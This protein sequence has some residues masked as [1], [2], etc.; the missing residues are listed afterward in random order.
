MRDDESRYVNRDVMNKLLVVVSL[1][2]SII[3]NAG[4]SETGM[5]DFLQIHKVSGNAEN[6]GNR[7]IVKLNSTISEN[8]CGEDQW[9]GYFDTEAGK[10]QYAAVLA[11]VMANRKIKI[12]G[13]SANSCLG[14]NQIIRNVYI[15][16]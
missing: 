13:T 12:G 9:T 7:F 10:A 14:G 2:F 16:I 6:S 4:P 8:S 15:V 11:A 3:A 5:V 1:F